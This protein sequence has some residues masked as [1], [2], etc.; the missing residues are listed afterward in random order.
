VAEEAPGRLV[1]LERAVVAVGELAPATGA[2]A[3]LL[4]RSPTWRGERPAA[5]TASSVFRLANTSLCLQAPTRADAPAGR[6]LSMWLAE[7]GEGLA[8]LAFATRDAEACREA[9]AARGLVPGAVEK[10]LDRDVESGAF[11]SWRG[12]ALAPER[13][14]G[15]SIS[16]L[17]PLSSEAEPA[18]G[19]APEGEAVSGLDHVVIRTPDP[20]AARSLYADGLGLRLALDRRFEA[21]GMRLLFFRVGGVTV[22]LAASLAAGAGAAPAAEPALPAD[23]LWGLSWRVGDA[24]AARDRLAAAGLDVSPVRAGRKPGTRVFTVRDAPA[25]IPTL[26]IEPRSAPGFDEERRT[27]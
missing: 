2:F 10:I 18:E 8:A 20:E 12:I 15:V 19:P 16:V 22:E 21:W 7:H 4:G 27:T 13:T 9:L 5:G 17:E 23:E 25:G 1:R 14:R 6:D 11:A 3:R 24:D 26:M